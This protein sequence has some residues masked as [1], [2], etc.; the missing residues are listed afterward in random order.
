[1][2]KTIIR[3]VLCYGCEAWTLTQNSEHL[4]DT[5]ERKV[6]RRIFGAVRERG[7]WRIRYNLELYQLYDELQVSKIVKLQRLQWA[8]HVQRMNDDRMP[9]KVMNAQRVDGA[10]LRGRP[11]ARWEH[12]V[13]EAAHQML[14]FRNWRTRSR[15]RDNWR[16]SI[17]AAKARRRAIVP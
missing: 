15:D 11:R 9:K 17:Q 1:M 6:L 14:G 2:Y 4:L 12:S 8:G 16:F 5:F 3:P 13:C 10:R 7:E